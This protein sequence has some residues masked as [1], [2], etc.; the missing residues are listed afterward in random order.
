MIS[1]YLDVFKVRTAVLEY[2]ITNLKELSTKKQQKMLSKIIKSSQKYAK[3]IEANFDLKTFTNLAHR[4][5]DKINGSIDKSDVSCKSGCARCCHWR[6][7]A[8]IEE[9]MILADKVKR[10]NI[11]LPIERLKAQVTNNTSSTFWTEAP[12]S[13]RACVFLSEK[14]ICQVYD[15]R[16]ASCRKVQVVSA[17]SF[18]ADPSSNEIDP[19]VT[20]ETEI[21]TSL[22]WSISNYEVD[23]LGIQVNRVLN[24][25]I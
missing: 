21:L 25:E 6:V 11:T 8:T 5:L 15:E 14:N 13:Q 18:C 23:T 10:E 7:D 20:L 9:A 2:T 3:M 19:L 4:E 24:T 12:L 17:P 16:P 1:Q 22:L